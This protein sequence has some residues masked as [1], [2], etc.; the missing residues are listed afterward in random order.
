MQSRLFLSIHW[1]VFSS[2][3]AFGVVT[4]KNSHQRSELL[5][6]L[7]D[8]FWHV[9][10]PWVKSSGEN[11]IM[12]S[13]VCSEQWHKAT[14]RDCVTEARASHWSSTSVSNLLRDTKIIWT[15]STNSFPKATSIT[16]DGVHL[17][18]FHLPV[19]F[20][21]GVG[22]DRD[23]DGVLLFSRYGGRSA[24]SSW[25]SCPVSRAAGPS[26]GLLPGFRE[27]L[28]RH[29]A[30]SNLWTATYQFSY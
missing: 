14:C 21:A 5:T 4:F 13:H 16:K 8:V 20:E 2:A 25:V 19:S 6:H 24:D 3:F 11:E 27:M 18:S 17:E 26:L 10:R 9:Q 1:K 15:V 28:T 22:E 23:K 30:W 29:L 7:E 12:K